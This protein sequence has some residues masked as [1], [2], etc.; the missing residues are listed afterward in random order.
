VRRRTVSCFDGARR[1]DRSGSQRKIIGELFIREF[2]TVA[3]ELAKGGDGPRF[4]V[5]GTLY[6]RRH[7]IGLGTRRRT[8]KSTTTTSA[9][10][11][12]TSSFDSS[13]TG[14]T[15]S[16]TRS[17]TSAK[18]WSARRDRLASAVPGPGLGVRIV[19]RGP[20][21]REILRRRRLRRGRRDQKAGLPRALA[22]FAVLP[23][24]RTVGSWAMPNY[25]YPIIIPRRHE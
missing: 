3:R 5:Q 9:A 6:P 25:A 24:V 8:F 4:L 11:P 17:A 19:A 22:E 10:Y 14:G 20:R 16:R 18:S 13:S 21:T 2:E 12:R 7:R 1:R 15:S 23:A